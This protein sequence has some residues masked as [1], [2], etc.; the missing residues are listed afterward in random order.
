MEIHLLVPPVERASLKPVLC[1]FI[2]ASLLV[3][4]AV[5]IG[6][7]GEVKHPHSVSLRELLAVLHLH[8]VN[9]YFRSEKPIS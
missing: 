9:R 1:F 3:K 5:L 4:N 8:K 6:T 7:F 2:F